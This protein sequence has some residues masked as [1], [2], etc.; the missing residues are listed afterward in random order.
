M[1][2]DLYNHEIT[3]AVKIQNISSVPKVSLS[4]FAIHA[5]LHSWPKDSTS[6]PLVTVDYFTFHRLLN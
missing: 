2:T 5:S 3:T 6:Q 4:S 1:N